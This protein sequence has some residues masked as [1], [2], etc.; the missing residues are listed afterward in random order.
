MAC[1]VWFAS[2]RRTG[3]GLDMDRTECRGLARLKLL[4]LRV[5]R[6]CRGRRTERGRCERDATCE[7]A[8]RRTRESLV[9]AD[10]NGI[11]DPTSARASGEGVQ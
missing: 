7:R 6:C 4:K 2:R 11:P 8:R 10:A 1:P 9:G 3:H 5:T